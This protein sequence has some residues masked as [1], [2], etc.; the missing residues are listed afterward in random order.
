MPPPPTMIQVPLNRRQKIAVDG[1]GA[2][3]NPAPVTAVSIESQDPSVFVT[4]GLYLIPAP[5]AS[6]G[7]TAYVVGNADG[8]SFGFD[9]VV[10]EPVPLVAVTIRPDGPPEPL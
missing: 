9:A 6:L 3:G 5:G 2:D 1:T 10:A 8:I 7:Q 4:N